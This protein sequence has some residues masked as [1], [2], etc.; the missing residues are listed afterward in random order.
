M[1]S[2]HVLTLVLQ[3]AKS[4]VSTKD[5]LADLFTKPLNRPLFENLR[6]TISVCFTPGSATE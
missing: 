4:D 6:N 2:I 1:L 5:Q 3:L